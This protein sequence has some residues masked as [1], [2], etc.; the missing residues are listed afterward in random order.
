M[1]LKMDEN[2]CAQTHLR[3]HKEIIADLRKL[4]MHLQEELVVCTLLLSYLQAITR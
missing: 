2:G 3:K 1:E 4:D